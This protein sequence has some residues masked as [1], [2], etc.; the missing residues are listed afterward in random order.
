[1]DVTEI[2]ALYDEQERKYSEHPSYVREAT[3]EVVRAVSKRLERLSFVIYSQLNET[4]ADR[5]IAEQ[6]ARFQAWGG[7]GFEW[8]TY[9]H[10]TPPDLQAR[11]A[12]HG[13]EGD[14]REGL[15]V[16]DLSDC[17][18]VYLQPVTADVR[19][20]GIEQVRDVTAVQEIVW[21]ENFD[22]L[23]EQLQENL[24]A[25]PDF[26]SIYVAYVDNKPVCAAWSNFPTNSLF[27]GLWGG[28]TLPGYRNRGLYTAVVAARAQ[29]ALQRGY[30]FLTVDASD[31]SRPILLKR[32]F[33]L[34]TYTTPY[35]WKNPD[36]EGNR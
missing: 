30:R 32:G 34:L 35:T 33:K 36:F 3:P 7:Y 9:D 10:D 4:N 1:M 25:Q 27:A 22:W 2:L 13:L 20:I 11:L 28:S 31:M 18:P 16:L 24:A 17:P 6:I 23:E 14:E 12:A 8:K 21:G 19:K 29:E 5:V 26:W 15:L